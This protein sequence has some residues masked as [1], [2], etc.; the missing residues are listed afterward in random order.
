MNKDGSKSEVL[1]KVA[2]K[3]AGASQQVVKIQ[4]G[5]GHILEASEPNTLLATRKVV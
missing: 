4:A 5:E 1:S 3:G 2:G